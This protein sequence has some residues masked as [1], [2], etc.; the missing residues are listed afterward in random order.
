MFTANGSHATR[1]IYPSLAEKSHCFTIKAASL[2]PQSSLCGSA[3]FHS[4]V[5][6][7]LC[8]ITTNKIY[9]LFTHEDGACRWI[10]TNWSRAASSSVRL[11]LMPASISASVHSI[12]CH[13]VLEFTCSSAAVIYEDNNT[14]IPLCD[15]LRC[16][17]G[18]LLKTT[19]KRKFTGTRS[20][21]SS[22]TSCRL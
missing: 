20:Q 8:G 9:I 22:D 17:R 1:S 11:P 7:E 12:P 18:I 4:S 6:A 16:Q 10:M 13:S 3:L 14:K 5:D 2:R 19:R 15:L 21:V